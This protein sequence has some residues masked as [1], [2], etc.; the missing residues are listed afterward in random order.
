[1]GSLLTNTCNLVLHQH[2]VNSAC[3]PLPSYR[4][5]PVEFHWKENSAFYYLITSLSVRGFHYLIK[6]FPGVEKVVWKTNLLTCLVSN[7]VSFQTKIYI[8]SFYFILFLNMTFVQDWFILRAILF[9]PNIDTL[10]K[11][12]FVSILFIENC[13]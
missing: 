3:R 9:S 12:F 10:Q 4:K 6:C 2:I 11:S 5:H 1:M 13:N 8:S 7:F